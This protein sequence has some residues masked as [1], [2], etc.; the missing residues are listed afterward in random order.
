MASIL[1]FLLSAGFISVFTVPFFNLGYAVITLPA[2]IISI[3]IN[4]RA[5]RR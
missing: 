2:A 4:R 1:Y 3:L 5:S